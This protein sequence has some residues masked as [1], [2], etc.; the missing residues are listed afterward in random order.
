MVIVVVPPGTVD[1]MRRVMVLVI[2]SS[3]LHAR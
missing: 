2:S 1:V 3:S